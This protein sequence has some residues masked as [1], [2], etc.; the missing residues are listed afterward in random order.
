MEA[1]EHLQK[2]VNLAWRQLPSPHHTILPALG[3][4]LDVCA[5]RLQDANHCEPTAAG[6]FFQCQEPTQ[7]VPSVLRD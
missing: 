3:L 2:L 1:E 6:L 5:A 7:E 4:T